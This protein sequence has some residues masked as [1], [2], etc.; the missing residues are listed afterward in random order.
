MTMK[1]QRDPLEDLINELV[2]E[3]GCKQ[4]AALLHV[5]GQIAE[6]IVPDRRGD[7]AK[8]VKR[9]ECQVE[10]W[11]QEQLWVEKELRRAGEIFKDVK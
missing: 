11:R 2:C 8:E 10:E 1:R 4:A 6:A 9:M 7:V 3:V 5:G